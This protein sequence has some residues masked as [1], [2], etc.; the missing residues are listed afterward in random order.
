MANVPAVPTGYHSITPYLI[1]ADG[2]AAID[3]YKNAFGAKELMK[4]TRPDGKLG[5]TELKIGSSIFMMADE[6]PDMGNRGPGAYGGSPVGI[7]LYIEDVDAVVEKAT[8]LGA[9]IIRPLQ[10]MFYG[11]RSCTLEDP[12]GHIWYVSTHVEDVSPEELEKRMKAM[13]KK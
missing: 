10:N 4:V 9:K 1:V 12:F 3:F 13:P 7:M 8:A 2:V 5:H 11:D 6:F